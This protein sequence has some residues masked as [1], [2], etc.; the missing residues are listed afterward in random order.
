MATELA[1][2]IDAWRQRPLVYGSADCCQFVGECVLA[3]RGVDYRE[4]FPEYAD[5]AEAL[6]LIASYGSLLALV[7]DAFGDALHPSRARIGDPVVF[8][9]DG[10]QVAGICVGVSIAAPSPNGLAFFPMTLAIAAWRP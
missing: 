9:V 7:S 8:E 6:G 5:E 2:V 1:T 3:T 4:E 10:N